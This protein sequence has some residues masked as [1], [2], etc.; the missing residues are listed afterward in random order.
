MD[1]EQ[2]RTISWIPIAVVIVLISLIVINSQSKQN[3]NVYQG[4]EP[5]SSA[6]PTK[7]NIPLAEY[8]SEIL[9]LTYGVPDGWTK[10]NKDGH[11]M[12]IH[13]PSSTSME[14]F[15]EELM[16]FL[17]MRMLIL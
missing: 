4:S 6:A 2:R 14:L 3:M 1:R 9:N 15:I 10:I 7:A 11:I 5:T 16:T 17:L 12:H 8:K 13:A